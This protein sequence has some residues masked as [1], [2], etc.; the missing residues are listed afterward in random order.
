MTDNSPTMPPALPAPLPPGRTTRTGEKT[1]W[2]I[3]FGIILFAIVAM[4][5]LWN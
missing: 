4:L 1:A 2:W 5:S 3:T